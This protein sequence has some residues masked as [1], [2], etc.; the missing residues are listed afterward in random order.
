[1]KIEIQS[2]SRSHVTTKTEQFLQQFLFHTRN[3]LLPVPLY[4][5][6]RVSNDRGFKHGGMHGISD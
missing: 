2:G 5:I 4:F 6:A 1:M 3:R